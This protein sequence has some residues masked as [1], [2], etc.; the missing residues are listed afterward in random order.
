MLISFFRGHMVMLVQP[1]N[2]DLLVQMERPVLVVKL[3]KL[4]RWENLVHKELQVSLV[5]KESEVT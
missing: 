2:Q 4:E 1:A 3:V 5:A